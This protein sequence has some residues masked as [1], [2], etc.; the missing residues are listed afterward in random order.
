MEVYIFG[1]VSVLES[2]H[3]LKTYFII[4]HPVS[5][6][7]VEAE[8]ESTVK[9]ESTA[10]V[11]TSASTVAESTSLIEGK[12]YYLTLPHQLLLHK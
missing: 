2:L 10:A 4:H 8:K 11:T 3:H 5:H 6:W 7:S 9:V 12:V 1:N